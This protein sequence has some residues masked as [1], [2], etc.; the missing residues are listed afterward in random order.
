M[1]ATTLGAAIHTPVPTCL[2][3]GT[4]GGAMLQLPCCDS[5]FLLFFRKDATALASAL[6]SFFDA[7]FAAAGLRCALDLADVALGLWAE[8]PAAAQLVR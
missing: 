3:A 4:A 5:F 1:L 6:A 2:E 7:D 8:T